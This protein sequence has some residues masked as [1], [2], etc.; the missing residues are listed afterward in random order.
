MLGSWGRAAK[1]KRSKR[2]S[3][4][5]T[6]R[7][8][9]VTD[10]RHGDLEADEEHPLLF[11]K[12]H[13]HYG[14][15]WARL[16]K[17]AWAANCGKVAKMMLKRLDAPRATVVLAGAQSVRRKCQQFKG[18]TSKEWNK[19]GRGRV[20]GALRFRPQPSPAENKARPSF[21]KTWGRVW[22]GIC[23]NSFETN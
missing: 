23:G 9:T 11:Q 8:Q 4:E 17:R 1:A 2:I 13:H 7:C 3:L 22:Q 19:N 21:K 14:E 12:I 18:H 6:S 16:K 10:S 20:L 15:G 5:N